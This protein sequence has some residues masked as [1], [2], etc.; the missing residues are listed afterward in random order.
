MHGDLKNK[1]YS[2]LH[3]SQPQLRHGKTIIYMDFLQLSQMLDTVIAQLT[4]N[5]I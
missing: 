4:R 2:H 5:R 3:I 1:I